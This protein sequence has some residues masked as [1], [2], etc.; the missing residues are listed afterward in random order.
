MTQ[1]VINIGVQPSDGSG[2]PLRVSFDKINQ[3]FHELYTDIALAGNGAPNVATPTVSSVNGK[4]GDVILTINDIMGSITP[5]YVDAKITLAIDTE[6]NTLLDGV[7]SSL[8]SLKKLAVAINDDPQFSL[9]VLTQLGDKLSRTTGGALLAPLFLH[10]DPTSGLQ[11]ATKQYVDGAASSNATDITHI[12]S[13]LPLKANT[14]YV[15]GLIGAIT[16]NVAALQQVDRNQATVAFVNNAINTTVDLAVAPK[17]DKTYVDNEIQG[18]YASLALLGNIEL[19]H[20]TSSSVYSKAQVDALLLNI[21]NTIN[22]GTT[23]F[24]SLTGTV[25][26]VDDY[27]SII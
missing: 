8:D 21:T 17:A 18:I 9:T 19:T 22:A 16:A 1:Q 14:T 2:D 7:V 6:H 25:T 15:D 27:G 3:N 4:T 12:L 26:S 5:A 20:A 13:E 10:A 24:G 23:D 11:A